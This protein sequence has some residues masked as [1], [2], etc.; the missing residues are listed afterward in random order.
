MLF[1]RSIMAR[2]EYTNDQ[3]MFNGGDRSAGTRVAEPS[4]GAVLPPKVAGASRVRFT[5]LPDLRI[6][7]CYRY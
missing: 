3:T 5:C 6:G 7:R 1:F 2:C 4:H